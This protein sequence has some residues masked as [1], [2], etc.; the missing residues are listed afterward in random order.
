MA[1]DQQFIPQA[2]EFV[3]ILSAD[4]AMLYFKLVEGLANDIEFIHL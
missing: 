4:F 1:D 2:A 3:F